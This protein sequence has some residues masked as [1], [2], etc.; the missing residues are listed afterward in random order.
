VNH[1]KSTRQYAAGCVPL[2]DGTLIFCLLMVLFLPAPGFG[3]DKDHILVLHSYNKGLTWTD[4][5]DAGIEAVLR[6]RRP[7]LEVHTEYLDTKLATDAEHYQR[8]A[9]LLKHKYAGVAIRVV[10]C[11]DD[12]AYN[13]ALQN[14]ATLFPAAA[15]VFC[16][17]NYFQKTEEGL[18]D[19]VT[20]VVEA[21][22][23]PATLRTALRLH[24]QA[25]K[26]I[27]INDRTTTGLANRK[28]LDEQ[29]IPEFAQ[30]VRFVFFDDLTMA[31]LL[32]KV[33]AVAPNDVILLLSFNK[34]RAGQVF[35]YDDSIARIAKEA[36]API[37][38]VWD[39]YLGKGIVGGML[40]SGIDQGRSAAEMVLRIL[41]GE[42]VRDI[43]VLRQ[44][45][46]KY[47]FDY[48]Q[49]TRFGITL[50]DLPPGSSVLNQPVSYYEAHKWLVRGSLAGFAGCTLIIFLLLRHIRQQR[51]AE[52]RLVESEN[53]FRSLSDD[54]LVGIYIIQDN[55]FRYINPK[56]IEILGY[57]VE[58]LVDKISPRELALDE[59]WPTVRDNL[60]KRLSDE[61]RSIHYEFRGVRKDKAI[62]DLEVFGSRTVIQ[63][64]PAVIGTLLDITE[65]KRA[66]EALQ[67]LNDELE[68]R[69]AERTADLVESRTELEM[70]NEELRET[71]RELEAE[72]AALQRAMED[73]REKEQLVI[74]Q[75]RMAAMG[76]MLGN[77]A[78]QWRQPFNVLGLLVQD[79]GLSYENG[80]FSQKLLDTNIG[81]VME[82]LLQLSQTID[83][84]SNFA[85]PDKEKT[86][87]KV[88]QV[89]VRTIS[90]I[91]ES[92]KNNHIAIDISSRDD[93]Q[94]DGYP[95]EYAQ[96]LLNILMNARDAFLES[97]KDHARI[98]VRAWKENDRSVVTI[99]DNAGGIKTE[100]LGKIFEPYFTTKDLGMGTGVGLFLSKTIIEKNM[101]G[102]LSASNTGDGVEL[103]IE[104]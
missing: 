42:K 104:V 90:L 9:L 89:I 34:D 41:D 92:F 87:F 54:A 18:A 39:F 20:G 40:T 81:K 61:Q 100:I 44:S 31:E 69:I 103:R 14:R 78:H 29:L 15:I 52:K 84:F 46:N 58:E 32:A 38:G 75:N 94:I 49:L 43:P 5:E 35:T 45:P 77:I 33:R 97:R 51:Q 36:A 2:R 66:E 59:D 99:T 25:T 96:V 26:V 53:R 55:L 76:E 23:L 70:Q 4:S 47:K 86:L 21:F 17:V 85:T 72:T 50:A 93:P 1:L 57:E 73:L 8:F 60:Q 7:Q 48:L 101:G 64:K 37:Y 19:I 3:Q 6:T 62:V 74:Q 68:Q 95:H 28:L 56:M 83:D 71:S 22:D 65:R 98:A 12:N 24:P 79:L 102:R 67:K 11:T 27:V 63:G 13:F 16:G 88:D 82:I 91:E 10:L 80:E 30:R